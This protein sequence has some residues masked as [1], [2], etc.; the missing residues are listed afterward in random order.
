MPYEILLYYLYTDIADPDDYVAQHRALCERLGLLG[1]IIVAKEGINGT[2][3]GPAQATEAYRQALRAAPETAEIQFKTDPAPGHAFP[4]LSIKIRPEIVALGLSQEDDIDPRQTT[5]QRLSPEEWQKKMR[6][7]DVLIIDGRNNYESALGR[8]EGALCPDLDSFRDFPKWIEEELAAQPGAKDR[9]ILTYCTGGIR[10]EKLSGLLVEKGFKDVSQLE[11]G[12]VTYGKDPAVQGQGFEGQCYV[13]DERIGVPVNSVDPKP[14]THCRT[15][16]E[17]YENYTN[18][19]YPP[20][21]AQI[22]LCP[23]CEAKQGRYCDAA[24]ADL[25]SQSPHAP[26]IKEK[27]RI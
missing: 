22:F 11:G 18:C 27:K 17:P 20:C 15:C 8:F 21:N 12:I 24:C 14:I 25:Q 23:E 6:Q 5:G 13:F 26:R 19:A 3:S 2:V 7:E 4:K 16:H 1:R 9:P 10:C